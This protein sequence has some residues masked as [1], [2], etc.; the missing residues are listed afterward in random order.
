MGGWRWPGGS[1]P[2]Q[3]HKPSSSVGMGRRLRDE[4]WQPGCPPGPR[5]SPRGVTHSA[6]VHLHQV[7][8]L[9]PPLGTAEPRHPPQNR[10]KPVLSSQKGSHR[11]PR[12]L[13]EPS[14][15]L[16]ASSAGA[17]CTPKSGHPLGQHGRGGRHHAGKHPLTCSR[18]PPPSSTGTPIWVGRMGVCWR[19]W[20]HMPSL[21]KPPGDPNCPPPPSTP[22]KSAS[23][24]SWP[25]HHGD[26]MGLTAWG[27]RARESPGISAQGITPSLAGDSLPTAGVAAGTEGPGGGVPGSPGAGGTVQPYRECR[28][29][30]G[31][32]WG[33]GCWKV[34]SP[35]RSGAW[36]YRQGCVPVPCPHTVSLCRVSPCRVP[37]DDSR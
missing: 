6:G 33:C 32:S 24:P 1:S 31:R 23:L 7:T 27:H 4:G 16:G 34:S 2:P 28:C 22:S 3:S 19:G 21:G 12:W 5:S 11:H 15:C 17:G 36:P 25:S 35:G 26:G 37:T 18:P 9:L 14:L 8:P 20:Y 10:A 13:L 29:Q 30:A